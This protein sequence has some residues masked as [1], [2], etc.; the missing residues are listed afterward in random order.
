M[1][2]KSE[3]TYYVKY[4]NDYNSYGVWHTESSKCYVLYAD[5]S[6]AYVYAKDMNRP[7]DIADDCKAVTEVE[8]DKSLRDWQQI[9]KDIESR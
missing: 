4:D 1:T 6:D 3:G 2:D 5:K 8:Y 9:V 7:P